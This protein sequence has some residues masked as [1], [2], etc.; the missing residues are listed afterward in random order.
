MKQKLWSEY[1]HGKQTLPELGGKYGHTSWWVRNKLDQHKVSMPE[2][3]IPQET[4]IVPDTTFWG[5]SYGVCVFRSWTLRK[6]IW[7]NEVPGEKVAHYHYG[8]NILE[9][10]GWR[11]LAAVVDGRRGLASVFK[12]IPVQV[13]HF[14]QMKT[15]TRYLTRRPETKAG[16]ELR[17]IMLKLP[18]SNEQEF[19]QL[20]LDWHKRWEGFINEKTYV[21][22]TKHWLHPSKS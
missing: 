10:R 5:R 13:C 12:D 22:G 4:I 21:A 17:A 20:L 1:T 18:G 19:N 2:D 9:E 16:Q 8:R 3:L 6:N 7:W 15:V 11:F 14:H